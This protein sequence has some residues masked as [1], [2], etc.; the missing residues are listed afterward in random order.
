VERHAVALRGAPGE[1]ERA[2]GVADSRPFDLDHAGAEVGEPQRG[3][4][5]GQELAEIEDGQALQGQVRHED[6]RKS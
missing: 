3:H 6:S 1:G 5:A 4:R 2:S